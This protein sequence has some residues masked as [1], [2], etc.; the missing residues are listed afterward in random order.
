LDRP[1][2]EG[3]SNRNQLNALRKRKTQ[4]QRKRTDIGMR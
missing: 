2:A 3:K 4:S 1:L